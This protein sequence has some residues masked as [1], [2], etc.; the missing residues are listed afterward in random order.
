MKKTLPLIIA[1]I[2]IF[3]ASCSSSPTTTIT[4]DEDGNV[5]AV[6][7]DAVPV[8]ADDGIGDG[9]DPLPEPEPEPEPEP[10][11]EPEPE[12]E[13]VANWDWNQT[14]EWNMNNLV[15]EPVDDDLRFIVDD[16]DYYLGANGYSVN[17]YYW[18]S[19]V[20]W[21]DV[22]CAVLNATWDQ[23]VYEGWNVP[24]A[25][26]EFGIML[27]ASVEAMLDSPGFGSLSLDERHSILAAAYFTGDC[28]GT[29]NAF[30]NFIN[31]PGWL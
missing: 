1:A 8:E 4:V 25:E 18:A 7:G 24:R 9:A 12:P 13:P 6:N 23:G 10:A 16:M 29:Y 14:I 3:G 15:G 19:Y 2:A 22:G 27:D 17:E 20:A 5:V 31:N 30:Y 28:D 21:V 26:L 11:P